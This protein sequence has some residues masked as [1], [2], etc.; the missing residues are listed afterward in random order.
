MNNEN[1]LYEKVLEIS[2]TKISELTWNNILFE[3]NL[4]IN[5][6]DEEADSEQIGLLHN[7]LQELNGQIENLT[8]QNTNLNTEKNDLLKQLDSEKAEQ[9]KLKSISSSF[10]KTNGNM[11]RKITRTENEVESLKKQLAEQQQTTNELS[12]EKGNL[13]R[14]IARAEQEKDALQKTIG[15]NNDVL[16]EK[17]KL[18]K[19]L[20][21]EKLENETLTK[22]LASVQQN[23]EKQEKLV[24]KQDDGNKTIVKT[25]KTELK[26]KEEGFN[27]IQTKLQDSVETVTKLTQEKSDIESALATQK[28]LY[29]ELRSK[30]TV[31][32]NVI[33]SGD[34][35]Q[36]EGVL[37]SASS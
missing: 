21:S 8:Q 32:D 13:E 30:T 5:N 37:E 33:E 22:E 15:L 28:N 4:D 1:V 26:Q 27:R 29:N 20:K 35:I 14:K 31:L 11:E 36:N 3:A 2:K 34:D 16:Q 23:I 25:L 12:Q 7:Q 24:K 17:N 19:D 10:E 6:V 18:E 9:E